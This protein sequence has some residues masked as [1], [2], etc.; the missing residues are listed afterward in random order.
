M[1]VLSS[2]CRSSASVQEKGKEKEG[3]AG[4][5]KKREGMG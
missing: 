5:R 1:Y 2:S 3:V 4:L